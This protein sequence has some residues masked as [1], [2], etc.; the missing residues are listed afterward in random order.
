MASDRIA[1]GVDIAG[2]SGSVDVPPGQPVNDDRGAAFGHELD[3][4]LDRDETAESNDQ[5]GVPTETT[6]SPSRLM[7][8]A[9]MT[10]LLRR[11]AMSQPPGSVAEESV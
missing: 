10:W 8:R 11:S 2:S 5:P 9:E 6:T 1:L 4:V 3:L 7:L